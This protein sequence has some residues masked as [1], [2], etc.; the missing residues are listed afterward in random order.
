MKLDQR[1]N[2]SWADELG[3][4]SA[5]QNDSN[6]IKWLSENNTPEAADPIPEAPITVSPRQIRQAL[7]SSDLRG[8]VES[9]VA[10]G[11]L[12]ALFDLA[13]SL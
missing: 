11:Q 4:H 13:A 2:Y 9:A 10:A 8:Q 6:V 1:G 5:T 12:H 3:F 7:T